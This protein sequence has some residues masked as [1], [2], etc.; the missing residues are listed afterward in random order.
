MLILYLGGMYISQPLLVL[1]VGGAGV[2]QSEVLF[3]LSFYG[4]C[5]ISLVFDYDE[6]K[7]RIRTVTATCWLLLTPLKFC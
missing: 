3:V 4:L 6:W 1:R 7:K 2:P 5:N